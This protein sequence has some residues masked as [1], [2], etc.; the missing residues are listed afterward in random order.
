MINTMERS[1][2]RQFWLR[3]LLA[4][5]M[6]WG[7]I[8]LISVLFIFRGKNDSAFDVLAAVSNSLTVFPASILAFWHRRTACIWLTINGAMLVTA[9]V[10]Y[11]WRT[12][13]YSFATFVGVGAPVLIAGFLG[14]MEVRRWPAALDRNRENPGPGYSGP[15]QESGD[16]Q[17]S[18]DR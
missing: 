4:F 18:G 15:R 5:G 13:E 1:R 10:S 2:L 12:H 7:T 3:V 16:R 6:F 9:F 17:K 14:Y 11:M 8:P